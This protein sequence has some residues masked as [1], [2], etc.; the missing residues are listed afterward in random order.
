M[1]IKLLFFATAISFFAI[2]CGDPAVKLENLAASIYNESTKK[3]D[4][5][6]AMAYVAACESFATKNPKDERSPE[7]L[8]KAAETARNVNQHDRALAIYDTVI[9][10]FS[11][12]KK[13]PQALFLKAFTLDD[14]MGKKDEAKALYEDFIAKYPNDDFAESAKFMLQKS[15]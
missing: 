5:E 10:Q 15:L 7:Y 1:K 11:S 6:K 14:N 3:I 13:A 9:E 4:S 8:L 2:S 12:F